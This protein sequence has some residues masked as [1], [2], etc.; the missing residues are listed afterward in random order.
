MMC[1]T[2]VK[3]A[4]L[5]NGNPCE[6]I[7]PSKGIRQGDPISPYLFILYVKALSA[8][9]DK[10]NI[11]GSITGVPTSKHGPRIS[12]LFF[13]N[14]YL[15]FCRSTISQWNYLANLLRRYEEASGQRLNCSKTGIFFSTN[16]LQAIREEIVEVVGIPI[17]Q[18]YD[19]YLGLRLWWESLGSLLFIILRIECGRG[20]RIGR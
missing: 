19:T 20:F 4:V 10:A 18:R 3:Y 11:E 2:T 12:H 16:T 13:A 14:Y 1:V 6:S 8:M 5:V 9:I 15:L 17:T 7:I